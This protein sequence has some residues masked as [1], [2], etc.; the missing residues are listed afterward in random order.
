MMVSESI[1]AL[2]NRCFC[3]KKLLEKINLRNLYF[4]PSGNIVPPK[5]LLNRLKHV[6][7]SSKAQK[8]AEYPLGILTTEERNKWADIREHLLQTNNEAALQTIDTAL[9][10]VALDDQGHDLSEYVPIVQNMLHGK[11]EGVI[12]RSVAM[13][14]KI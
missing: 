14:F 11:N 2:Y 13:L 12:N 6:V 10:C 1:C 9:F 5:V 3:K 4:S 8:P 7:E